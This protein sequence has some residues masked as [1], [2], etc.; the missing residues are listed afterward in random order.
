LS[1]CCVTPRRTTGGDTVL[2]ECWDARRFIAHCYDQHVV[3][4]T[5]QFRSGVTRHTHFITTIKGETARHQAHRSAPFLKW[6]HEP[7]AAASRTTPVTGLYSTTPR[8]RSQKLHTCT[9]Q[10]PFPQLAHHLQSW[11]RS[12]EPCRHGCPRA[13]QRTPVA[14]GGAPRTRKSTLTEPARAQHSCSKGAGR[15]GAAPPRW[16][17]RRATGRAAGRP[18][19]VRLL[20]QLEYITRN[21]RRGPGGRPRQAAYTA[22]RLT[23]AAPVAPAA[24][25]LQAAPRRTGTAARRCPQ[26]PAR[27]APGQRR[28]CPPA[29]SRPRAARRRARP[30]QARQAP[31]GA[32]GG[33]RTRRP[34]RPCPPPPP[35]RCSGL[36]A[37][38]GTRSKSAP[39]LGPRAQGRQGGPRARRAAL[40]A[41]P[42]MA[43][44]SLTG[45][46]RRGWH[47]GRRYRAQ[48]GARQ[49][50]NTQA[51]FSATRPSTARPEDTRVTAHTHVG[52]APVY[53]AF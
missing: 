29:R 21:A 33:T 1:L 31:G 3:A 9:P 50:I 2:L 11:P 22:P 35:A 14:A 17:S 28:G 13:V 45:A 7:H 44:C 32:A 40:V 47:A 24:Q 10:R 6:T 49:C 38:P 18:A 8:T 48:A 4:Y 42:C 16:P 34:R 37:R 19:P 20:P 12:Q 15:K 52:A 53:C 39:R 41:L 46:H 30:A 43:A 5:G 23:R 27:P 51:I 36:R 25:R 26:T